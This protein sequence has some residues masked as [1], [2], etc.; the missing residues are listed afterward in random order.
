MRGVGA[1][2]RRI[3]IHFR[4]EVAEGDVFL[5]GRW[6]FRWG[7]FLGG[8][9]VGYGGVGV[10]VHVD[11]GVYCAVEGRVGLRGGIG[12]RWQG[13]GI[14]HSGVGLDEHVKGRGV[15]EGSQDYSFGCASLW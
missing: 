8:W 12:V 14:G 15:N 1:Y 11:V 13:L 4:E 9:R 5:C 2:Y 10:E 7:F 3:V 6:R